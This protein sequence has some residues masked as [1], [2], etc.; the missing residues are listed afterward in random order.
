MMRD[1]AARDGILITLEN[2]PRAG[3]ELTIPMDL[4]QR[5]AIRVPGPMDETFTDWS[6]P[7]TLQY[8]RVRLNPGWLCAMPLHVWRCWGRG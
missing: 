8:Q 2:G 5:G 4:W 7:E 3:V 1:G 6:M